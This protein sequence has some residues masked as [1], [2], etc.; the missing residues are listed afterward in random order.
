MDFS[1]GDKHL[2]ALSYAVKHSKEDSV[3]TLLSYGSDV[4]FEDCFS[5]KALDYAITNKNEKIIELLLRYGAVDTQNTYPIMEKDFSLEDIYEAALT[6]N[7]HALT[8][9][10]KNG[11]NIHERKAN[12]TSLLH[13][14]IDGNNPKLLVYLLNKG[15]NID[16]ADKS[17]TSALILASMDTSRIKMLEI[18]IHRNATLDQRNH[19]HTSALSMAIK[20][21][22]IKAAIILVNKGANINIRDSIDTPLTLTHKALAQT[23]HHDLIKELRTLE[24][25]LL[26]KGAHVNSSDE[27]LLW[28]PLMLTASH[29][30]DEQSMKQLKLLL[31]LGAKIN[32]KD[33][34][35]RTALMIAS[36]LGRM[37]ALEC[38]IKAK[39]EQNCF[40]K[41]GWTALMLAIYYNQKDVVK[42]LLSSG[43]DV[44][45][46]TKKGLSALKVAIDNERAALIPILKDYGAVYPKE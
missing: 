35:S 12:Y 26:S 11:A 8:Y 34:N 38:L 40:D 15:L 18:L 25:L 14:C 36:S 32:Q 13:L 24:T 20:R 44:N 45:I 27:N 1:C 33:K 4:N 21:F 39:A 41:F 23:S 3:Q 28:S 17:G 7:L 2:K 19:R 31:K 5:K 30:Q 6:G 42:T 9:F 37:D 43:A 10:H 16:L 22:N 29:Y 46:S